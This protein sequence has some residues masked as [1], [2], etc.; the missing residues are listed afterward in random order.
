[1]RLILADYYMVGVVVNSEM[2][3]SHIFRKYSA[4]E[5]STRLYIK[6]LVKQVEEKVLSYVALHGPGGTIMCASGCWS[7]HCMDRVCVRVAVSYI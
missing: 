2:E 5:P 1:M 7:L 6:N 4:G 3:D